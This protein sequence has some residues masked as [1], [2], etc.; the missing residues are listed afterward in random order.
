M[1]KRTTRILSFLL[2]ATIALSMTACGSATNE[3][4][5]S[6]SA[7]DASAATSASTAATPEATPTPEASKEP[8]TLTIFGGETEKTFPVG[9]QNDPVALEIQKKLGITLDVVD[10]STTPE[11]A[12]IL[13]ASGDLPDLMELNRVSLET[14]ITNQQII[15]MD[16]L[17]Q[18]NGPDIMKNAPLAVAYS[19]KH[20]SMGNEKVFYIPGQVDPSGKIINLVAPYI[21]WDYYAELGYPPVKSYDDLLGVVDQMLKLHPTNEAGQKNF[22]FSMWFDWDTFAF[23]MLPGYQS[24]IQPM[25]PGLGYD[26]INKVMFD[27]VNDDSAFMWKG[28]HFWNKAYRMGLL[29]LDALTQKYDQAIQKGGQNRILCMITQWQQGNTNNDL[30]KAGFPGRGIEP[31]PPFEGTDGYIGGWKNMIG[32]PDRA[33]AISAN[34]KT[35]DRAMD[36][37]NYMFSVEGCLTMYNGVKDDSW[38]DENGTYALTDKFLDLRKNDTNFVLTTG[39]RKYNTWPGLNS[40]FQLPNGQTIELLQDKAIEVSAYTK[41]D[42]DYC[43]YYGVDTKSEV[44]TKFAKRPFVDEY[45]SKFTTAT[46][47]D[48]INT[49]KEKL[50]AHIIKELPKMVLAKTDEELSAMIASFREELKA[51]DLEKTQ[52]WYLDDFNK[53]AATEKEFLDSIK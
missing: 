6:A 40:T 46:P 14:L 13:V 32:N 23:G 41:V 35:P 12:K 47:P 17:L 1:S 38:K 16:S 9:I 11:K 19:R 25:D 37:I 42:K 22:G 30:E 43:A 5:A 36:L 39:A 34:C 28:V 53:A 3:N 8:V 51:M 10:Q 15:E 21:R 31:L 52:Q 20:L 2:T 29:D 7:S 27:W 4:P 48:D 18:T 44:V 50:R 49:A 33:W 24:G 45:I 26:Q